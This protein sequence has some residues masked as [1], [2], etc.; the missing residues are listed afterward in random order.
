MEA[1]KMSEQAKNII[2]G[3]LLY[4]F[5]DIPLKL[6]T[7]FSIIELIIYAAKKLVN[8]YITIF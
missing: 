5:V 2:I 3:I 6:I 7:G 4:F 1:V 8:L